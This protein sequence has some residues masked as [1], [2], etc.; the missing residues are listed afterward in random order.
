[1]EA[2]RGVWALLARV[3]LKELEAAP[4][5]LGSQRAALYTSRKTGVGSPLLLHRRFAL[6]A[7]WSRNLPF[8]SGFS[9]V[10][11]KV[12]IRN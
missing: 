7:S 10:T 3:R 5:R 8:G 2:L 1:M 4:V 6:R 12:S 11:F 9:G